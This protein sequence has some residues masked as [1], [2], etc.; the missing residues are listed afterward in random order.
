M[1]N[2]ISKN[3]DVKWLAYRLKDSLGPKISINQYEL[4]QQVL[5]GYYGRQNQFSS[6]G[7]DFH[8]KY[9]RREFLRITVGEIKIREPYE[10]KLEAL[11]EIG[12]SVAEIIERDGLPIGLPLAF[13]NAVDEE[14]KRPS[15]DWAFQ[16]PEAY[17]K[18]LL[19]DTL[20]DDASVK[21][22]IWTSG[23]QKKK[24]I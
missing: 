23:K 18:E 10:K 24:R 17:E 12:S 15:L 9:S 6:D 14:C 13:Y 4:H 7:V 21:N 20:F 3:D 16:N 11:K 1:I 22:L 5:H 19:E 2:Y 8:I